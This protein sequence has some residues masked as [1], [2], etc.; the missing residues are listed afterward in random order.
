M[1]ICDGLLALLQRLFIVIDGF[2]IFWAIS[3]GFLMLSEAVLLIIEFLFFV[4][5]E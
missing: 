2:D 3:F 5:H 4:L 1:L